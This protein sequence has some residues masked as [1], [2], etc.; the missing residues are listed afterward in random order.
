[1]LWSLNSQQAALVLQFSV[2]FQPLPPAWPATQVF[3]AEVGW[4]DSAWPQRIAIKS[5]T[6]LQVASTITTGYEHIE[7]ALQHQAQALAHNPFLGIFPMLLQQLVPHDDNGQ[8]WLI[9]SQQHALPLQ[10]AGSVWPLLALSAGH[11]I[12][13]FGE[14]DGY[15]FTGLSAWTSQEVI[16]L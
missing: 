15:V 10:V 11:P 3:D 7:Q 13:I 16:S 5:Q 4:Y 14:W 6:P 9:D 1:W 8:L 12:S 2:G